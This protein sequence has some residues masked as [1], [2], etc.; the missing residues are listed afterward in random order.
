MLPFPGQSDI[1]LYE[2]S[3][4]YKELQ[5]STNVSTRVNSHISLTGYYTWT[6]YHTNVSG[7]PSNEYNTS[8]DWG[9]APGA[10]THRANIIGTVGLP[11]GWTA[12]PTISMSS[13]TPFNITTGTDLNGDR[14]MNDRPAFAPAGATCGGN[15]KCT[16][17][18]NF[19]IAPGP[20]DTI[21]PINYGTGTGRFSADVRFSRT[22][23]WGEKRNATNAPQGG[24]GGG[25]GGGR[26]GGPGGGGGGGGR[27]GGGGGF[28]GGGGR[29]GGGFGTVGGSGHRYNIGLTIQ[30]TNLL[31]HVNLS[32]PVGSLNSPFFGQ[33]LSSI[34]GGQG[35]G[36]GGSTATGNRRIQ[37]TLRFTY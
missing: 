28:G 7:F 32:N 3:G 10:A 29:G 25:G 31:N 11:L 37:F 1:Y 9:R 26:G 30:A 13:A 20:G 15:I 5:I 19:N 24:G 23:G 6:N 14:I 17:W 4:K 36:G 12:S 2:D 27:G 34:S 8:L 16:P 33:S 18:G 35:L 22:W 21:I